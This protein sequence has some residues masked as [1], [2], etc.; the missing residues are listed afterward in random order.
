[1]PLAMHVDAGPISKKS[2]AKIIQWSSLTGAGEVCQ[3]HFL[4]CSWAPK[5]HRGANAAW[6]ALDQSFRAMR[7]GSWPEGEGE[8]GQPL[9]G[10]WKA[11][12]LFIKADNEG[13]S[14]HLSLPLRHRGRPQRDRSRFG[15][16]ERT[17]PRR[18]ARSK[19]ASSEAQ[20]QVSGLCGPPA[21]W[22]ANAMHGRTQGD[23]GLLDYNGEHVCHACWAD[24]GVRQW[25]N[26]SL[27]AG[28][29]ATVHSGAEWLA[30]HR[31]AAAHEIANFECFSRHA[32]VYDAMHVI[33]HHGV[34]GQLI[35]N[36]VVTAVRRRE[37]AATKDAVR[38]SMLVPACVHGIEHAA[39]CTRGARGPQPARA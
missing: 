27:S 19:L 13:L 6:A 38:A 24:R 25:N 28:W 10:Q 37:L 1:M 32:V 9:A 12:L 18:C 3:R 20:R 33:D 4:A 15:R 22:V 14:T 36:L 2:S 17:S 35:S 21:L 5:H 34:A 39:L 29:R 30:R 16:K 31:H 26:F 11:C 23:F 7:L 8:P